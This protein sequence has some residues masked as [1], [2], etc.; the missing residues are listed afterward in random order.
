MEIIDNHPFHPHHSLISQSFEKYVIC[1]TCNKKDSNLYQCEHYPEYCPFIIC[2]ECFGMKPNIEYKGHEHKLCF[3]KKIDDDVECDADDGYCKRG[4][5]A[6]DELDRT[7]CSFILRCVPCNFNIVHLL[8]GPLPQT[9]KYEYHMHRLTLTQSVVED[10]SGEYVCDACEE[11]R[12]GQICVYYCEE[13]KFVSHVHCLI[14][15]V[16]FLYH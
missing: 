13:C 16:C 3:M 12:D 5:H 4:F 15:Q 11:K 2:R 1:S 14:K 6:V 10:T 7:A 9:I 8:C